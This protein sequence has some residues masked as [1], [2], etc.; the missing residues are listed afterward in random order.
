MADSIGAGSVR[1]VRESCSGNA[2]SCRR[3]NIIRI[4]LQRPQQVANI[5]L[6]AHQGCSSYSHSPVIVFQYALLI[7]YWISRGVNVCLVCADNGG[8]GCCHQDFLAINQ[9][10]RFLV[11]HYSVWRAGVNA[12]AVGGLSNN[13]LPL[14]QRPSLNHSAIGVIVVASMEAD[15]LMPELKNV[16]L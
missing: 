4:I 12:F 15:V 3:G 5:G 7:R 9:A 13:V 16:G 11:N 14:Q 8:R 2:A 10:M 6:P 1:V